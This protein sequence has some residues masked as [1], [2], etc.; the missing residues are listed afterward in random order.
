MTIHFAKTGRKWKNLDWRLAYLVPP[1][2]QMPHLWRPGSFLRLWTK[3]LDSLLAYMKRGR[4]EKQLNRKRR[5]EK[6]FQMWLVFSVVCILTYKHLPH[7]CTPLH[8]A[9]HSKWCIAQ[10]QRCTHNGDYICIRPEYVLENGGVS[11]CYPEWMKATNY[12]QLGRNPSALNSFPQRRISS[13]PLPTSMHLRRKIGFVRNSVSNAHV[14]IAAI[15]TWPSFLGNEKNFMRCS[16]YGN[17][18]PSLR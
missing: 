15:P 5:K 7:S 17:Y 12:T 1:P 10:P 9:V 2:P 16:E 11:E 13:P 8:C 6:M 18:F 4:E 3:F 14:I